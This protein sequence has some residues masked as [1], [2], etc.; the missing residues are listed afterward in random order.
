MEIVK[1]IM[2]K[3]VRDIKSLGMILLWPA[4][5]PRLFISLT[6]FFIIFLTI[7]IQDFEER[8]LKIGKSDIFAFTFLALF[9]AVTQYF[10][11]LQFLVPSKNM[12]LISFLIQVIMFLL[13]I[14]GKFYWFLRF[15][16]LSTLV[17]SF[18]VIFI[19]RNV[20]SSM[21]YASDYAV[22]NLRGGISYNGLNSIFDWEINY[23][24]SNKNLKGSYYDV[25]DSKDLNFDKLSRQDFDYLIVTNETEPEMN[26]DF[27]KRPY[28][29]LVT[30]FRYNVSDKIIF[31]KV[32]RINREYIE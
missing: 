17:W 5:I 1:N 13:F 7:S 12:F 16:L 3:G 21:K 10:L 26:F 28:L 11:K 27:S 30:E 8:H 6:P 24:S 32:F 20:F 14:K 23:S 29:V 2:K 4:A 9:Y 15:A 31:S 19:H 22:D 18:N 25:S